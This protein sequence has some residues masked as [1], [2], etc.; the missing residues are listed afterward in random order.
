[1][2]AYCIEVLGLFGSERVPFSWMKLVGVVIA[3]M[4]VAIF[5]LVGSKAN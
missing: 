5:S 3:I 4:G 2:V 1:L